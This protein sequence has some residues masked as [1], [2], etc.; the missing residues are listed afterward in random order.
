MM[1]YGGTVQDDHLVTMSGEITATW[2]WVRDRVPNPDPSA[3]TDGNPNNDTVEDPLDV[4]PKEVIMAQYCRATYTGMYFLTSGFVDDG[5]GDCSNGLGHQPVSQIDPLYYTDANGNSIL[6]GYMFSGISEGVKYE[7]VAGAPT[8]QVS[9]SPSASSVITGIGLVGATVNY[10]CGVIVPN[11][12]I[13]GTT[14]FYQPRLIGVIAGQQMRGTTGVQLSPEAFSILQNLGSYGVRENSQV[15]RLPTAREPFKDFLHSESQGKRLIFGGSDFRRSSIEFYCNLAGSDVV[16]ASFDVQLPT[17][18]GANQIVRCMSIS[19]VFT[20]CRPGGT[21]EVKTGQVS[22]AIVLGVAGFEFQG[23]ANSSNG[24]EWHKVVISQPE[25]FPLTGRGYFCQLIKAQR[26]L[27]RELP[28][29]ADPGISRKWRNIHYGVEA[30]DAGVEYPFFGAWQV[31]SA[32]ARGVDSPSQKSAYILNDGVAVST[33]HS[34]ASDTFQTWLM[35]EPPA[36]AG[37]KTVPIPLA[38]YRWH[39]AC[40]SV[41]HAD[42]FKPRLFPGAYGVLEHPTRTTSFPEWSKFSEGSIVFEEISG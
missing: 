7:K 22:A 39:W 40:T 26:E 10:S 38:R 25:P 17:G 35:Y 6:W 5:S 29:T 32:N 11:V 8:I 42:E 33:W 24:Q 41:W 30:L 23:N 15:W 4:P 14:D 27:R 21:F 19:K 1:G 34:E 12:T 18:V 31:P 36:V 9:C 20:V 37:F 16:Q 28:L 2:V 3:L 13:E